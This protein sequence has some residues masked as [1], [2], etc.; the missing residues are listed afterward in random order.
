MTIV[1]EKYDYVIGIDTHARTHTYAI[2]N[3]RTG[4]REDCQTFPTSSN[5]MNRALAWITKRT[6]G[7]LLAA[8]EGTR[9][10]GATITHVLTEAGLTVIEVKPPR[11]HARAGV[12]K[13]DEIDATAAA[14]GIVYQDTERL[15][16]PR[17]EGTRSALNVLVASRERIDAERTRNR[18]A[19]NA[20]VRETDLGVDARKALTDKQVRQVSS[21]REHPTDSV[22]QRYAR[23]E[24]IR[25]AVA[26]LDADKLLAANKEQ[27]AEIDEQMA[28]GLAAE[29]GYGP[30]TVAW[31]LIA[32]SH[33]GR[34]H[35]E[36]AFASMAGVAPLQASSGNTVR[37]RL[38]RHGDRKLNQAVDVIAKVRMQFDPRTKE[39]V[40]KRKAEGLSYREIK[41]ILKRYILRKVFRQLRV[42][43]P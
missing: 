20:L 35:S 14:M 13:T 22:A 6:T 43:A 21:W 39:Y 29:F 37:H 4:T 5:G 7:D 28:P 19:L 36:A 31:I 2:V 24:A 1:A 34:V 15:L 27:M 32:Y 3:T 11:K 18:N 16:T 9:S 12:G 33:T 23:A 25:L 38:N 41:R 40:E 10:Y 17:A 30:V 42:L 8:V 26:V